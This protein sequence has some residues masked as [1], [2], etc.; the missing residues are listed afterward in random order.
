M[1]TYMARH[2]PVFVVNQDGL[3]MLNVVHGIYPTAELSER[4]V[5]RLASY[6][7]NNVALE[8]YKGA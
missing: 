6:L 4:A 3:G 2:P 7:N 1:M 5:E 8:P